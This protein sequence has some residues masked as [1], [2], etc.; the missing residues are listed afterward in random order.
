MFH[1]QVM[2]GLDTSKTTIIDISNSVVSFTMNGNTVN[3]DVLPSSVTFAPSSP[4]N[5]ALVNG[6]SWQ[7]T[8]PT[9]DAT[10]S[11][12]VRKGLPRVVQHAAIE[13]VLPAA[14][15]QCS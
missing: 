5:F 12:E 6:A 8:A 2:S 13:P 14:C 10:I 9:S 3:V 1:T 11:K 7:A 15:A 4:E